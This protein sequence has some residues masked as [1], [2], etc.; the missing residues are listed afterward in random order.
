MKARPLHNTIV[1]LNSQFTEIKSGLSDW[2]QNY[3]RDLPAGMQFEIY[4]YKD[5]HVIKAADQL[6]DQRFQFLVNF[7]QYINKVDY[8]DRL[9]AYTIPLDGSLYPD[10]FIGKPTY[11]FIPLEDEDHDNVFGCT[12]YSEVIK[13][14]FGGRNKKAGIDR[15][16]HVEDVD[17]KQLGK[18]DTVHAERSKGKNK[19][20]QDIPKKGPSFFATLRTILFALAIAGVWGY[21]V[22]KYESLENP[23]YWAY[24]LGV[25]SFAYLLADLGLLRSYNNGMLLFIVSM[26]LGIYGLVA[27]H[28]FGHVYS[29][30]VK[31]LLLAPV[32]LIVIQVP[33]RFVFKFLLRREPVFE[34]TITSFWNL[35]YMLILLSSL[36]VS[37]WVVQI[38]SR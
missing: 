25:G 4:S 20:E 15:S 5:G 26:G 12:E 23:E 22:G 2:V 10:E 31:T 3:Q 17:I 27:D 11:L 38:V 35:L 13:F 28:A 37:L 6:D 30:S 29:T 18:L 14:D 34:T 16:F 7:M 19:Q 9:H 24:A 36:A 32:L 33:I 8:R 21:L 1:I